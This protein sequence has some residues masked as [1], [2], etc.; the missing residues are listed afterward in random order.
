MKEKSIINSNTSSTVLSEHGWYSDEELESLGLKK[1][2]KNVL[3]SKDSRIFNPSKLSVGDNVRIDALTLLTGEIQIGKYCHIPPFCSL[4]GGNKITA[5][6]F[7]TFS[8]HIAVFTANADYVNGSS[9]TNPTIP[10]EFRKRESGPVDIHDHVLMGS[11][12]VILPNS[13][14]KEGTVFGACSLIKGV[15]D[16]WRLYAGVPAKFVK[17]RPREKILRDAEKLINE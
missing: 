7:V 15:Y 14:L 11:H 9:L 10:K 8:T 3:I 5:G 1:F 6:N 16:D 17:E 4:G 13:V 12:S 2:G